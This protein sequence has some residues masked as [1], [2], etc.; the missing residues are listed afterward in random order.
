[1]RSDRKGTFQDLNALFVFGA[2]TVLVIHILGFFLQTQEEYPWNTDIEAIL[3]ILLRFGRSLFI[4]ATGML[5]FYWYRHRQMDWRAFW[6]KRWR[7]I[8]I[9][10]MIWTAIYTAFKLQTLDPAELAGP[11]FHS[12]LTGSAFYHLYYIPLYLQLNLLFFLCKDWVEKYLRFWM[13]ACLFLIQNGI[14]LLFDYLFTDPQ[15]SIDWSAHPLLSVIQYGYVNSQTFVYMYLF[16]FALG[17]YAGLHVDK[18][19]QWT[20]RLQIPAWIIAVGIACWLSARYLYGYAS[21]EE[22]LHIFAPVYLVYTTSFLIAFYPFSR[23]LG[24]LPA[25]GGFLSQVAKQNMAIYLVHPLILFLLESYVIFR[26]N[27]PV[28]VLMAVMFLITPPL[29]IFLYQQ[30]QLSTWKRSRRKKNRRPVYMK[31]H[32][33]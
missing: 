19:R 23:Y 12:L 11:F 20:E 15:R 28:P 33:A 16:T 17:A 24:K 7:V 5:L 2:A 6:L 25:L 22:S 21:Y 18:W 3:L 30:T 10:Y 1:M 4:F 32:G 14:Y 13:V 31:T 26:L 29:C 8:V 27:W 9:P